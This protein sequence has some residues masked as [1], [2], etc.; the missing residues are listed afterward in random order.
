VDPG[1]VRVVSLAVVPNELDVVQHLFD[2]LVLLVF[3]LPADGPEIHGVLYYARIVREAH[4]L[5]VDWFSKIE[6]V[7]GFVE[8][9]DDD[10]ELF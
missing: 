4:A 1:V 5:P 6:G 9:V 7:V 2:F 10:G 3:D 8:A